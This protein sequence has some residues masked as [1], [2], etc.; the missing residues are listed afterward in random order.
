[1]SNISGC[2]QEGKLL[3]SNILLTRILN[4]IHKFL[5]KNMIIRIVIYLNKKSLIILII[6]F[7]ADYI[8]H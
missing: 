1:M 2:N 6:L 5:I 7:L 4:V 3:I 8:K